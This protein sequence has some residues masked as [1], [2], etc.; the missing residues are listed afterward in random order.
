MKEFK[1]V[2]EVHSDYEVNNLLKEGWTLLSVGFNTVGEN[3]NQL[4]YV[5]GSLEELK[6][7]SIRDLL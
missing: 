3:N 4:T 1:Q 5:L 7:S 2:T 6:P